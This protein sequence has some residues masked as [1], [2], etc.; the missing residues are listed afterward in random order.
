MKRSLKFSLGLANTEKLIKLDKLSKEY[1]KAVNYFLKRLFQKKDLSEEFLKSYNSL[2]SYRFKQCAKR[3]S[4][5]IFKSWCRNKKKGNK[6]QLKNPSMTL[7][8]R[9]IELQNSK[10]S[11]FDFWVKITTLDKGKPILI[12]LK[13]YDYANGYFKNWKLVKGGKLVKQDNRWFLILNFEKQSIKLKKE[14]KIIGIDMGIKKLMVDSKNNKYGL[15]IERLMD[16]IQRKQQGS[17]AFKRALRERNYY[18]N[19]T[20]KEL[21]FDDISTIVMENIKGIKKNTKKDRKL[22]KE[23]RSK[24]QR[25]T[26]PSL[27]KRINELTELNGVHFQL[28]APNYT[29]QMCSKCSFVHKQNRNGEIFK[30]RNCGYTEDVDYNASLN[31]LNLGLAQQPMVAGNIKALNGMFVH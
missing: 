10:D 29:S 31:I 30:C 22:R 17:K 28:I 2:L 3:Q 23:F 14:G 13:T 19:R 20:V 16:K 9:F 5:K 1:R 18:I 7:D 4:F 6:P 24:F 27:L 15:D 26:Y 12:P 8:Y 21:P 25:W 11:S